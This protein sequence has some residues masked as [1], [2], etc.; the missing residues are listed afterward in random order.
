MGAS[1]KL[2]QFAM[3]ENQAKEYLPELEKAL[4]DPA[5]AGNKKEIEAEIERYNK[6]LSTNNLTKLGT[7]AIY[8]GS[9][10]LFERFGTLKLLGDLKQAAKLKPPYKE[11]IG[12]AILKTP[13]SSVRE[14]VTEGLTQITQ[15]ASDILIEDK[16]ISLLDNVDEAAVQGGLIGT[17]FGVAT[18]SMMARAHILDVIASKEDK[19]NIANGLEQIQVLNTELQNPETSKE[20][21][22]QIKNLINNKTKELSLNED[23]ISDRFLKL[24]GEQQKEVFELDRK[25]REI[26]KQWI[27]IA[28][29]P[30]MSESAKDIME[31]DYRTE[32]DNLQQT[33]RDIIQSADNRYNEIAKIEGLEDGTIIRGA[34][35]ANA[36]LRNVKQYNKGPGWAKKVM[37]VTGKDLENINNFLES[38]ETSLTLEDKSVITKKEANEIIN[39][40]YTINENGQLTGKDGFFSRETRNVVVFTDIAGITNPAAAIHEYMHAAFFANGITK[41]QFDNVK[42]D[43]TELIK[44]KADGQI[45]QKQA[46][47]ILAKVASYTQN[48][49]E[50]LFTA[51]SDF[52]NADVIRESDVD[53]LSKLRNTLKGAISNLTGVSEAN[54]FKIDTAE[55]AFNFIKGF[56]R[57]VVK[58]TAIEGRIST[59]PTKE[60]GIAASNITNL[61]NKYGENKRTMVE[62]SF[63]KTP[64]GQETFV[65]S[66]SEFGQSI[67]GLLETITKRIYDPIPEDLKKGQSRTEFKNDLVSEAATIIDREY[68]AEKQ[69]IGKF[70]TNRLNLRANRLEKDLGVKQKIEADVS[71]A[72]GVATEEVTPEIQQTKKIAERLGISNNI[73]DKAKDALEVGILNAENK[74]EGTE[75]LSGKKRIAIRDKAVNDIIDGKLYRDIQDEFGRN[76]DTSKSFTDYLSNN[77]SALRDAALKHINFQ[78][79]NLSNFN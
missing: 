75:K 25:S 1:G 74:L 40:K 8:A 32:F 62:Q 24:S 66:E 27:S 13:Q 49:S 50:E 44:N 19:Q 48:Q 52:T 5:Y 60:E 31:Q 51:I 59:E 68:D 29:D 6:I 14:G 12:K 47:N 77:F 69:D 18:T 21:K 9:E 58:G 16:N 17:G 3:E 65:P 30:T 41:E 33:K 53:F 57:K 4:K 28:S 11:G 71:E 38:K 10:M 72:K 64:S 73:I 22:V 26:N 39:N 63:T 36:N 2:P 15:N 55:D 67:G 78:K 43:L 70:I 54:E 56:N 76:T 35:V 37:G 23:I 42:E 46:D 7:S 45:T 79:F 20:R 61:Y 34:Q